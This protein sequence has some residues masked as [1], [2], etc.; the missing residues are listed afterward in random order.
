MIAEAAVDLLAAALREPRPVVLFA[1][2]SFGIADSGGDAVLDAL[3][4]RLSRDDRPSGWQAVLRGGLND[5]DMEWLSER[6]DRTVPSEAALR[7]FDVAWSAV[8]TSSI[9]QRFVRRFATRGRQ[10]EPVLSR[11]TYARVSRSRSRPPVYYLL[12]KADG[13]VADIR[14]PR[15][16]ADLTRRIAS[17]ATEFLN[18]VA[19]TATARGVVVV[20]GY[21]PRLDWLPL[22][23]LLAPLS[24]QAG[25]KVLWFGTLAEHTSDIA[26][27]MIS[28]GSLVSTRMTLPSAISKLEL[29]GRIDVFGSAAPDDPGMVTIGQGV[30]DITPALRLRVEA[31]AVIVDDQ[32][33]EEPELLEGTVIDEAF[34]RFHGDLGG[35]RALVE[36]VA[37]N[38]AIKRDF[39][40][41]LWKIFETTLHRLSQSDGVI[42]VHGQSG[43]GK[44]IAVARLTLEVR[45]Q[46]RLPVLVATSRVPTYADV[47]AF[48]SEAERA[49]SSASVL[50]CDASQTP[51]RYQ[52]LASAMQ[53]RGR[54]L[55]IVG[56]S[57]RIDERSLSRSRQFVE[58]PSNISAVESSALAGLVSRFGHSGSPI[59]SRPAEDASIL[60]MLYRTLSA[61]R[62]RITAGVSGEARA[63]ESLVRE[64]ARRTPIASS[65][66]AL[67]DQLI[68][69]GIADSSSA[70]FHDDEQLAALGQDA[71]GRLIDYVM[72]AGRLGCPVPLNLVMRALG[73]SA[74][75]I[76]LDHVIHL[77]AD[78][79]LFRWRATDAEGSDLLISPRLQL[80]AE[81]ICRRRLGDSRREIERLIELIRC[82]RPAGVDRIGERNFLLDLLQKLDREGPRGNEYRNGYLAFADALTDLREQNGVLDA[83]LMLRE[84]V[85]RRQAVWSLDGRGPVEER[86]D[87][88]RLS[89][90][91]TARATVEKALQLIETGELRASKRT[92]LHLTAERA[93]IYG[94]LA[95]Q[96]GRSTDTEAFWSDYLAAKTASA[97]AIAL[98]DDYHPID[99][100]LWTSRDVLTGADLSDERRAEVVAD[101]Y[102]ALDL[103][104]PSTLSVDQQ[105][106]YYERRDSVVRVIG[107][108]ELSVEALTKLESIAPAA[109]TFLIAKHQAEPI[110]AVEPPFDEKMRAFAGMTAD[111]VST[112]SAAGAGDDARCQRL[113][114]KLRWAEATGERLLRGERGRT[115]A[116]FDR[117]AE[118][119]SIVRGLNERSG[120]TARNQ[121][122]YLDAVLSWLTKDFSRAFEIW[123]SLSRDTEY[124]DRSRVIRRLLMT[125]EDGSPIR[126]RGRVEGSKGTDD[127]RVRVETLNVPIALLAHEFRNEDLAHGRELRDFGIAFNYVG[128][129][130]DSLTRPVGRR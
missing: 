81:L 28:L 20:A 99:V 38:F 31:S 45:R 88:E 8:F 13:T 70:L 72:A 122:R 12:G 90:L 80:E 105:V 4:D 102:A 23:A 77:F 115:P 84:C 50:I 17:H 68:A 107:D 126:F 92:K 118:L 49:G 121:E 54:R 15:T 27:E 108:H 111:F 82:V 30:L 51:H 14:A 114:L 62:E 112:R 57:Y 36:G 24:E 53:S 40:G 66:S 75:P 78:L 25:L 60:A 104:D 98:S 58:A 37:R 103:V 116:G 110:D 18:R 35:F 96:R 109:A 65:R 71:A 91:N 106:R 10:P 48:C 52:D 63:V 7:A 95:V 86:T 3:L 127:W 100:A 74:Q 42:I 83:A 123:R 67:A 47:D 85:F 89:I 22:D 44:S 69:A 129:I 33:T 2:Q 41:D 61:G 113:L 56:T 5:S 1:G 9:D 26:D 79:D 117:L 19:E 101:L 128:P 125:G 87:V 93:S 64:R 43:T 94:Y 120:V 6:F 29:D 130:A 39:E 32:W 76:D 46:L 34:R 73:Q 21:D 11:G 16:M 55:L 97:R 124:E 59:P 119:L